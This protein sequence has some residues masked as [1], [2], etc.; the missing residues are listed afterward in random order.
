MLHI[1]SDLTGAGQTS[2]SLSIEL[3]LEM[4]ETDTTIQSFSSQEVGLATENQ[5]SDVTDGLIG[6]GLTHRNIFV[7]LFQNYY[8]LKV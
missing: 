8:L 1:K 6:L 7:C 2:F 5:F 3:C 4:T